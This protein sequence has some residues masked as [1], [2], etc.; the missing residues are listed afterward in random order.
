MK[1]ILY[2]VS[3]LK[4]S[5][6][7]N[8]LYNIIRYLDR[9][10]FEPYLITL[11]PEQKDSRWS[12]YESLGIQIYSLKMSRLK[13]F[14]LA[15]KQIQFL[16]VKI[17]PDI[18]HTQGF[19]A[20]TLNVK[21]MNHYV[22]ICTARNYPYYDYTAKYGKIRGNIMAYRHIS[23]LKKLIV[24]ACSMTIQTQLK[25]EN[26]TSAVVQNGVD[27]SIYY[28]IDNKKKYDIRKRLGIIEDAFVFVSVGSI[29]MRKDMQT[30]IDAFNDA[31][32]MR[33]V[34]LILLGDGDQLEYLQSQNKNN[35]ILFLGNVN[36]VI[37][38]LQSADVFISSSLAE[39]LPNTVLE[40]MSCGLPCL[41]SDI[42]SHREIDKESEWIFQCKDSMR[43]A[44][45]MEEIEKK[46]IHYLGN[47]GSQVRKNIELNFSSLKMSELYQDIY[48]GF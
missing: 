32:H 27:I 41:L 28:K 13:G 47:L 16:L 40:A 19:R 14:I 20:D 42:P 36:N 12:D 37:E 17:K 26:I 35:L 44:L 29:I 43:L 3:T 10:K 4:R 21:F 45:L 34:Q 15:K 6:P 48:S 33:K 46:D 8:Q 2:I 18:I 30:I 39:G 5:G 31:R 22:S 9:S 24:I 38:Y 25:R 7:S 23:V 11:S 1:K